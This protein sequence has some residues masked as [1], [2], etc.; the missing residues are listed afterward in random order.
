MSEEEMQDLVRECGLDW[1]K[2]YAPL[3]EGDPTNRYAVLIE[4][5]IARTTKESK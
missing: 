4:A 1:Y 5:V 3:F 2:G